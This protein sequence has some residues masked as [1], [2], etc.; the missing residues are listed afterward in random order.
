M[1]SVH[2]EVFSKSVRGVEKFVFWGVVEL[3]DNMNFCYNV[4]GDLTE[5]SGAM[6]TFFLRR[7]YL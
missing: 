6:P 3:D 4:N 7:D 2:L 1:E 5:R